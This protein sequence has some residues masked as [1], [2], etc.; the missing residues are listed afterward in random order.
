MS[1][2]VFKCKDHFT[3]EFVPEDF[4]DLQSDSADSSAALQLAFVLF[5]SQSS[6]LQQR[7]SVHFNWLFG[8][9]EIQIGYFDEC[10]EIVLVEDFEAIPRD[11]S[12]RK[13]LSVFETLSI[14]S[15]LRNQDQDGRES[16][17][18]ENNSR[19][20]FKEISTRSIK[21]WLASKYS[22]DNYQKFSNLKK[23]L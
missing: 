1:I 14:C 16:F 4:V 17:N 2:V 22:T 12:E 15:E 21:K 23:I 5:H 11:R 19:R 18:L 9:N 20:K 6:N 13:N 7:S 3:D 10:S 8:V